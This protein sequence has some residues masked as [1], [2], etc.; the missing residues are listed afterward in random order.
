MADFG[1][2]TILILE[3]DTGIA[4]LEKKRLERAGYS[5]VI[6]ESPDEAREAIR[7]GP[8]G[9][10]LLDYRLKGYVN[11][12]DFYSAL[13]EA[14]L[15]VPSILITGFSD[16]GVLA[17]A[18]R[19]GIRDFL[20]KTPDYLDYVVPAVDRVLDQVR[21][22]RQ[23]E[24]ERAKL[25]REQAARAEAE[26]A[27]QRKDEFLATLAH[28]LRNPLAA[29]SNAVRLYR[30][31][32]A[33][34]DDLNW[35]SDVIDRQIK[36]LSRLLEDLLDVSRIAVGKVQLRMEPIDVRDSIAHAIEA[37][38]PL[39]EERRH[40]WFLDLDA[41]TLGVE[42]DPT[43]I[44][45]I[46]M[47]LL[48]NAAK[49]TEPGGQVYVVASRE[50]GEVVI[51]VRDTGVGLAPE[52]LPRVF[53][54]FAQVDQSL[55]RS[56]GGLGIGLT[57]V[58]KLVE[59]HGGDLSVE[60]EGLGRGCVFTVRLPSVVIAEAPPAP[61][62]PRPSVPQGSRPRVLVV[63][64]NTDT[65][66]GLSRLL[67]LDGHEVRAAQ[68]GAEAIEA[69]KAFRPGVILMDIGLPGMDGHEV[70]RRLRR[71]SSCADTVLVA[72]SG[73]GQAD[74]RRKSRE[75]GFDHHLVKPVDHDALLAILAAS[76]R[77]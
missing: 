5:A 29:I 71:D 36:H 18:L 50:S 45:Q 48:T 63:D 4:Q 38:R 6:A 19:V 33:G 66:R 35:A 60:S 57:L 65:V 22:E 55:D 49:Y 27:S 58:K 72:I 53:D 62:E 52:M 61:V 11:G 68:D 17:Q 13:R 56:H 8:V 12:L 31:S 73:Y 15:N 40:T 46:L 67:R 59:M 16:E 74:D 9:L 3:D 43:R 75:A 77:L 41:S 2:G 23:L 32:G 20:P 47:N 76:H 21:T 34:P 7:N 70:A 54:L 44:E 42:A 14:G 37:T 28:E 30:T 10:L 39:L 1:G 64:D 69:A 51:R 24:H 26:A 25:I